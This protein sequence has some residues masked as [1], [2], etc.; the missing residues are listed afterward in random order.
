M[1]ELAED[2]AMRKETTS[3]MF[4]QKAKWQKNASV[5]L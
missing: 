5:P 3:E 4:F 1:K 2:Y